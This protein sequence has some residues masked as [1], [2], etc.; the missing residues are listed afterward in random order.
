MTNKAELLALLTPHGSPAVGR[1]GIPKL[2]PQDVAGAMS[3]LSQIEAELLYVKYCGMPIHGLW[4]EWFQVIMAQ[5]WEAERG[6]R[7]MLSKL[8][9]ADFISP[10]VCNTCSGAGSG[11]FESKLIEC[12]VCDG[13]GRRAPSERQLS[14]HMGITRHEWRSRWASRWTW[15]EKEL[16]RIEYAALA[17]VKI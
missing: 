14:Q 4:S 1:G 10:R 15:C 13:T 8:S 9:L 11:V 5:D 6:Q 12:R 2:T 16:G 17:K 3:R 7:N